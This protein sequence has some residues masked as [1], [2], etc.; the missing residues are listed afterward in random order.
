MTAAQQR[1]HAEQ[2]SRRLQR[3]RLDAAEGRAKTRTAKEQRAAAMAALRGPE[4]IP[5]ADDASVYK[6]FD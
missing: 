2:N 4:D 1:A 6:R 5:D 3:Q